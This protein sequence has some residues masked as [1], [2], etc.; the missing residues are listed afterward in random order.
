MTYFT[1]LILSDIELKLVTDCVTNGIQS[2]PFST[3]EIEVLERFLDVLM[4]ERLIDAYKKAKERLQ[5]D[6]ADAHVRLAKLH[7]DI[8]SLQSQYS[9]LFKK[10]ENASVAIQ[11]KNDEIKK[12]NFCIVELKSQLK[13]D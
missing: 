9:D 6:L 13:E 12:L 7:R 2:L 1:N 11:Q 3:G 10:N 8:E 4:K 5:S